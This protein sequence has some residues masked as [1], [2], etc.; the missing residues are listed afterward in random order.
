MNA[1]QLPAD[2]RG[3]CLAY[4]SA[5]DFALEVEE[6]KCKAASAEI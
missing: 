3:V 5:A 2:D 1:H 6:E 4:E